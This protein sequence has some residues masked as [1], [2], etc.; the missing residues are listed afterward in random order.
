L[1]VFVRTLLQLLF[2]VSLLLTPVGYAAEWSGNG[3]NGNWSE[4]MNWYTPIPL[5]GTGAGISFTT[6]PASGATTLV[7][8]IG[9]PFVLTSMQFY[10]TG[11]TMM[12]GT[13]QF[14]SFSGIEPYIQ[15]NSS[16]RQTFGTDLVLAASTRVDGFGSGGITFNGNISGAGS[17]DDHVATT[18]G[19]TS[20]SLGGFQSYLAPLTLSST[21]TLASTGSGNIGF[22]STVNAK[23]TPVGLTVNTSGVTTFAGAVG[24]TAPLASLTTNASGSTTLNGGSVTTTGAQFYGDDVNLGAATTLTSTGSG[25]ITFGGNVNGGFALTVNTAG[26]T[27]FGGNVGQTTRLVS[28]T[29]DAAGTV[30]FGGAGVATTG[31]Q[32]YNE[33][34]VTFTGASVVLD[35]SGGNIKFAGT[36]DGAPAAVQLKA[37]AGD[38]TLGG[39]V[40]VNAP[41]A[42]ILNL[43]NNLSA[44]VIIAGS[45]DIEASSNLTTG[46]VVSTSGG[47]FVAGHVIT[48]PL[49]S[50]ANGATIYCHGGG[51]S[52]AISGPGG[53]TMDG[54]GSVTLTATNTYTG[55]TNVKF[56]VLHVSGSIASS[57][58]VS[59]TLSQQ[60]VADTPQTIRSLV[61]V[62]SAATVGGSALKVGDG[63]SAMPLNI[64]AVM[65]P[66]PMP[67]PPAVLQLQGHGLIVDYS[68]GNESSAL[69]QIRS[70]IFQGYQTG[71]GIVNN[72]GKPIG[73]AQASE[74]LGAGGGSFLGLSADGTSVVARPTLAGDTTLDGVV[75]FND[76]VLLAQNYN[77]TVSAVTESW[78]FRG[79]FTGDGVVNFNDLVL[80]AQNYG[81][82]LPEAPIAGAAPGFDGD[83]AR[84]LVSVPEPLAAG[85]LATAGLLLWQMQRRVGPRRSRAR[86]E[87]K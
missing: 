24:A 4:P 53:F 10:E 46:P 84:A 58:G 70:Y 8:D 54:G 30:T 42:S 45:I 62:D 15:L 60:F 5:S 23:T 39:A 9:F 6:V 78:W 47:V 64:I 63:T 41:P 55:P 33:S 68:P 40:G 20:V 79:D 11:F 86:G 43:S 69:S 35:S 74:V 31:T 3:P 29:T 80:L 17:L 75:N 21:I 49:I 82:V 77:T 48:V 57:S 16:N 87:G 12:G 25:D 61:L 2:V 59:V 65:F 81:G 85:P 73:Y 72:T 34:A 83:L 76:L 37:L 38:V 44:G 56:G 28:V 22:S 66:P 71:N 51:T 26:A 18:L 50:A 27:K 67:T 1:L 7:Q 36:L 13:I 52:G 19:G 32:T 14:S